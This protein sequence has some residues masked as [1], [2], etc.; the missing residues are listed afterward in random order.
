MLLSANTSSFEVHAEGGWP[1]NNDDWDNN[2][3]WGNW[4][5]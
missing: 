3:P 5:N 1:W 2:N 4:P